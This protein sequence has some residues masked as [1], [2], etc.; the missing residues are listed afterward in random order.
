MVAGGGGGNYGGYSQKVGKYAGKAAGGSSY[1]S[2]HLGTI[3]I[4]SSSDSGA[5][6]GCSTGNNEYEC[7]YHYSSMVFNQTTMIDGTGYSWTNTCSSEATMPIF[8]GAVIDGGNIG[9][10]HAR[11]NMKI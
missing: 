2:G 8:D 6:H 1:I 7:S 9:N 3:S 11:K 5:K 10:G 4:V